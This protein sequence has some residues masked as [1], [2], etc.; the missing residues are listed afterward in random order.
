MGPLLCRLF[1]HRMEHVYAYGAESLGHVVVIC[2]RRYCGHIHKTYTETDVRF[3][4]GT[5]QG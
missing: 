3:W 5:S 2:K 4:G 1:G